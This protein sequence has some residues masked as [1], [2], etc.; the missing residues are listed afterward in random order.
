MEHKCYTTVAYNQGDKSCQLSM[1]DEVIIGIS[2]ELEFDV[3]VGSNVE[4]RIRKDS[5]MLSSKSGL[6][7]STSIY[8]F[9]Q[10]ESRDEA[11]DSERLLFMSTD[12]GG[13]VFKVLGDGTVVT[14]GH[15][16]F[17]EKPSLNLRPIEPK[18]GRF[19]AMNRDLTAYEYVHNSQC[20]EYQRGMI[21]MMVP[22]GLPGLEYRLHF[23]QLKPT[24]YSQMWLQKVI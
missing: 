23:N 15:G 19:F 9:S 7:F 1:P 5:L 13:N 18:R 8:E 12:S 3:K 22:K 4:F 17:S 21:S 6:N 20:D 14:E 24:N 2:Q 11:T 16:H 10:P